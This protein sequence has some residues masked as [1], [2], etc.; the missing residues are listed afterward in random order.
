MPPSLQGCGCWGEEGRKVARAPMCLCVAHSAWLP[1]QCLFTLVRTF[2]RESPISSACLPT[3]RTVWEQGLHTRLLVASLHPGCIEHLLAAFQVFPAVPSLFLL[4]QKL[5]KKNGQ[6]EHPSQ[7]NKNSKPPKPTPFFT[8]GT[9][10]CA[11]TC[12][13]LSQVFADWN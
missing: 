7:Q 13:L 9:I 5:L 3:V 8:V 11:F 4:P 12:N 1:L 10:G 6:I 2:A